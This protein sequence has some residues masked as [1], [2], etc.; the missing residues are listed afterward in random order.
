MWSAGCIIAELFLGLPLFG[1]SS[2]FGLLQAHVYFLGNLPREM[3]AKSARK[4][5]FFLLSGDLKSEELYCAD[6]GVELPKSE[7]YFSE[8]TLAATIM[9]HSPMPG[10]LSLEDIE[11]EAPARAELLDL[12]QKILV[13]APEM[14]I[15]PEEA[16][17]HPFL[18]LELSPQ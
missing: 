13:F 12:L 7:P 3:I 4:K 9:N 11:A 2:E 5:E 15:S 10:E 17:Q 8:R 1:A 18:A 6:L 14:R 16:M